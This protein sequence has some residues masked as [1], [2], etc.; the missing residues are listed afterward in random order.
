MK[1]CPKCKTLKDDSAFFIKRYKSGTVGLRSYCKVC[2][3]AERDEYRR[4]SNHDNERNKRYNQT[5]ALQIASAKL[6]QFWPGSTWQQ[7]RA[8]YN[9][10]L[11]TQG[12]VCAICKEKDK[13]VHRVTG[14]QW[15]L[16]VDHCH[17]TGEVRGLLCNKCN[18][19]L[20]LLGD[21]AD[22]LM[23]AVAYLT[24]K[25]RTKLESA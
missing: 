16:A 2:S 13:R 1:N 9:E 22:T 5:H 3:T 21:K 23:R 24:P 14:K 18:R 12:G 17:E 11:A 8:K 4:T 10:L 20:G 7:A 6:I 19:G 25:R 15:D